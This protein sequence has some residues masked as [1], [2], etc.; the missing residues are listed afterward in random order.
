[1]SDAELIALFKAKTVGME[2][3]SRRV[4]IEMADI[5]EMSCKALVLRCERLGLALDGSWEWFMAN[6][7]ISEKDIIA[8]RAQLAERV[9]GKGS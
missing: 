8:A 1:M 7:G 3:L 2:R 6:G 9:K 5:A 4:V